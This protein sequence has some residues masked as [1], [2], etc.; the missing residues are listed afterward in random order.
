MLQ[1]DTAE[2]EAAITDVLSNS[3][4]KILGIRVSFIDRRDA[5]H[6][7]AIISDSYLKIPLMIF[8]IHLDNC[9]R[10]YFK[11]SPKVQI[12]L[13]SVERYGV[14]LRDLNL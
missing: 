14:P 3:S 1:I 4:Q 12:T 11:M 10:A 5:A 8:S 9:Q 13:L 6:E 7:S 2:N